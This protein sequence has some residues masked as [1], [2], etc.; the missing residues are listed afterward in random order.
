MTCL[1]YYNKINS[2]ENAKKLTVSGKKGWGVEE[3]VAFYTAKKIKIKA[4]FFLHLAIS[5]FFANFKAQ[6]KH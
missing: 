5:L 2:S 1:F 3:E 6:I 4:C